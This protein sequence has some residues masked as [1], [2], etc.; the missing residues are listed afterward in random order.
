MRKIQL[1][2]FGGLLEGT[3]GIDTLTNFICLK[4]V[5]TEHQSTVN[6]IWKLRRCESTG[7]VWYEFADIIYT[8]EELKKYVTE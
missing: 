7:T 3:I 6:S 4:H 8:S 1:R 5:K 2:A